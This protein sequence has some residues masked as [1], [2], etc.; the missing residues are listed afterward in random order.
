MKS[1]DLE[2]LDFDTPWI[3]ELGPMEKIDAN[4]GIVKYYLN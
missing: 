4:I 2:N 3:Y 1:W